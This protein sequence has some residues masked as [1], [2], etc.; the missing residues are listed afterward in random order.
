MLENV[1]KDAVSAQA[2]A[3]GDKHYRADQTNAKKSTG[4]EN[5]CQFFAEPGQRITVTTKGIVNGK[6][7]NEEHLEIF[8]EQC[9]KDDQHADDGKD[10][11]I[12]PLVEQAGNGT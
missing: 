11:Q 7:R 4:I 10:R 9:G 6:K 1:G 12:Y 5:A 3:N 8:G 2:K